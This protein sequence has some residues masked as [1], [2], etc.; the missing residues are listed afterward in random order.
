M[1]LVVILALIWNFS[2]LQGRSDEIAFSEF[3]QQ[4]RDKQ[5]GEVTFKGN[6]IVGKYNTGDAATKTFRTT[7]P[8][9]YS[10]LAKDLDREYHIVVSAKPETAGAWTTILLSW[11]PIVLMIGFWVFIMRQ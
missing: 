1:V 8:N 7:A 3:M 4:V 10:D 5:V 11:A 6:E 9:S 2:T